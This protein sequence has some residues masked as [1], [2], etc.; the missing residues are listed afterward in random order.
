MYE[1]SHPTKIPPK[2]TPPM[3]MPTPRILIS[4]SSMPTIDTREISTVITAMV[5]LK[6]KSPIN[7]IRDKKTK[8]KTRNQTTEEPAEIQKKTNSQTNSRYS[9]CG[10]FYNF[11]EQIKTFW[12]KSFLIENREHK[13]KHVTVAPSGCIPPDVAGKHFRSSGKNP[14]LKSGEH[15]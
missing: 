7:K 3:P 4:P 10:V 1:A 11:F 6:S 13:Q 15:I 12:K 8:N 9:D 5:L 14:D 2:S